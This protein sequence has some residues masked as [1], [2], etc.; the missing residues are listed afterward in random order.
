MQP[1]TKDEINAY[2]DSRPGWVILTT[3]G[4]TACPT[5]SPSATSASATTSTS[6]GATARRR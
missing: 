5:R 3:L 4:R 6:A 1:M 2:I